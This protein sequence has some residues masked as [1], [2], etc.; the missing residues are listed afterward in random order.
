MIQVVQSPRTDVA[1]PTPLEFAKKI[2][3]VAQRLRTS[4]YVSLRSVRCSYCQG[5]LVLRGQVPTFYL[6]Q[7]VQA[8]AQATWSDGEILDQVEVVVPGST[9]YGRPLDRRTQPR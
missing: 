2:A 9:A 8:I 5:K 6:R 4:P 1:P 3:A 7:L